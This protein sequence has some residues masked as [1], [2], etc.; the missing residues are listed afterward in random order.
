M[1]IPWIGSKR[2][3]R[4]HIL[5]LIPENIETYCEPFG[6][7]GWILFAKEKWAKQEVYND[8]NDDLT[9]LFLQVKFHPEALKNE[10]KSVCISSGMFDKLKDFKALTELQKAAQFYFLIAYSFGAEGRHFAFRAKEPQKSLTNRFP[11]IDRLHKRLDK[12]MIN[13]R[14]YRKIFEYYDREQAFFY[15]D[16]PY[17]L[18]RKYANAKQFNHLEL[19]QHLEKLKGRWLLSLDDCPESRELFKGYELIELT[20]LKGINGKATNS[21]YKEILVANYP[22]LSLKTKQERQPM[23]NLSSSSNCKVI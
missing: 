16:P 7:A 6:G 20:R 11:I 21:E 5:P 19:K 22:I 18:G 4:K 14:D 17:I 12:V 8:L 2:L 3:L 15:V 10:L 9:N 23:L 13:N 1:I